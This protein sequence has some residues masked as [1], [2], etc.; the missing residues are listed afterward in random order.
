MKSGIITIAREAGVS[1]S[2]VSRVLNNDKAVKNSTREKVLKVAE[3]LDYQP[4]YHARALRGTARK[5]IGLIIPDHGNLFFSDFYSQLHLALS[6]EGYLVIVS[7]SDG[8]IE[9]ERDVIL[10]MLQRN[11]DGLIFFSYFRNEDNLAIL[12]RNSHQTPIIFLDHF[13]CGL[14]ETCIYADGLRGVKKAYKHFKSKNRQRIAIIKGS[15]KYAVTQQRFMGYLEAQK[16][17]ND[18]YKKDLV[19]E[20]DFQIADGYRAARYFLEQGRPPDAIISV[21]D[22]MAI[23]ALK[24]FNE[25]NIQLPGDIGIIGFDNIILCEYTIPTLSTIAMPLEELSNTAAKILIES[26]KTGEVVKRKIALEC[27]L[28]LRGTS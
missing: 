28:I 19:Y 20:G 13:L 5:T 10:E 7:S 16:E 3:A 8:D 18:P 11:V 4:N 26:I 12:R 2:T 9:K 1:K 17:C 22:L 15:P 21:T 14:E 24:Y 25:K 23:G 6:N 27:K